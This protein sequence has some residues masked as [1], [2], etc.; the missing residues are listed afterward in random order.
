MIKRAWYS[1]RL[2]LSLMG[3]TA[4]CGLT[5]IVASWRG[6]GYRAGGIYDRMLR[7]WGSG[8][9]RAN[10]VTCDTVGLE[11]L[12]QGGSYVFASNHASLV[13]IWVL[14]AVLPYSFRF[15]AKAELLR[16]PVFGPAMRSAGN[17]SIDRG[18]AKSA[19]AVYQEAAAKIRAGL[20][21]VVFVEGTRSR[22][23]SLQPFK[24]GGF[25]LAIQ[26]GVPVVPVFLAGTWD[27]LPSGTVRLTPG[28]AVAL[29]GEP[30]ET[31]GLEVGDREQLSRQ[32]RLEMERLRDEFDPVKPPG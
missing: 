22:D 4:Y 5:V 13:D 20:S 9:C 26:A 28:R 32:V 6:I 21:A 10:G 7:L 12:E 15:V 3:Y 27:V 30:I 16:I 2:I 18:K 29:F 14:Q 23:G 24:R 17:I 19:L 25:Q 1:V 11:R 31:A 8:L